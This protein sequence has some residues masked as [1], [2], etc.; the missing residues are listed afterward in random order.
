[1]MIGKF[2]IKIIFVMIGE[3]LTFFVK[4]IGQQFLIKKGVDLK[5][6]W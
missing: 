4:K 2:F 1:M 3:I 6:Y 5:K